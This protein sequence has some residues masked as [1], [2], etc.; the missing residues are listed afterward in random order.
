MD[1]EEKV[2][3]QMNVLNVQNVDVKDSVTNIT[4]NPVLVVPYNLG[5]NCHYHVKNK[6]QNWN[7]RENHIRSKLWSDKLL[8]SRKEQLWMLIRES[9]YTRCYDLLDK[10]NQYGIITCR[11]HLDSKWSNFNLSAQGQKIKETPNAGG[12]SIISEILAYETLARHFQLYLSKTE[13]EIRYFPYGSKINDF[14]VIHPFSG[15]SLGVSVTRAFQ[16]HG[17]KLFSISD[18]FKLLEKKLI[19]IQYATTNVHKLDRWNQ[20]ILFVWCR[21]SSVAKKIRA[22]YRQLSQNIKGNTIVL[23]AICPLNYLFLEKKFNV[24]N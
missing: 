17:D 22:A 11:I 19:G 9:Q 21:S 4:N 18:A 5:K 13:M 8:I 24:L 10:N 12:T 7:K 1:M 20:S 16:F 6:N 2:C 14:S 15:L 23:I 3:G